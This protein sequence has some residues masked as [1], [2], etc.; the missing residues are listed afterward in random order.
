LSIL[1]GI[2]DINAKG[3]HKDGKLDRFLTVVNREWSR[4]F[5]DKL[6]GED[7]P[8]MLPTVTVPTKILGDFTSCTTSSFSSK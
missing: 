5:G 2:S 1:G 4:V 7:L 3:L 6:A 8:F